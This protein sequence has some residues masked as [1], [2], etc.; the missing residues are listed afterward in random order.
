MEAVAPLMRAVRVVLVQ[1][2]VVLILA[3]RSRACRATLMVWLGIGHLY[4]F[5]MRR[6]LGAE[7]RMSDLSGAMRAPRSLR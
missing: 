6:S 7:A 5:M 1:R 4:F 2:M 3:P